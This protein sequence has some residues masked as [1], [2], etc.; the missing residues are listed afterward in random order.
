MIGGDVDASS[1]T[2]LGICKTSKGFHLLI[3]DPH[4][5]GEAVRTELQ[6]S[7]WVQWKN[8]DD[9]FKSYS[10]YNFCLPQLSSG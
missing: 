5:Y 1:K 9:V 6:D 7:G 10:F 2:L 3:A 4:F 8:H